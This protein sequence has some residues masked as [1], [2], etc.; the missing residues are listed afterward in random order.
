MHRP[1]ALAARR[2]ETRIDLAELQGQSFMEVRTPEEMNRIVM[3]ANQL[4]WK[5]PD[6][7]LL[8]EHPKNEYP[9]VAQ[10]L[11]TQLKKS[12]ARGR[13]LLPDLR[14]YDNPSVGVFSD[15]GGESTGNYHVYSAL[16]CG[17]GIT[18]VF[19]TKMRDVRA[20]HGLGEKEIEFKDFGMG[21]LLRALPDYL[22]ALD[23]LVPG[24]LCTLVVDKSLATL[25][26]SPEG[27]SLSQMPHS[28]GL[29]EWKPQVAEKLLRVVHLTAFLAA[30]LTHEGQKIF[31]M[32]DHDAICP[33]DKRHF[34]LLSVFERVLRV[35]TRP[36]CAFPI[37][38][39]AMPFAERSVEMMDLL[40]T[41]DIVAGSLADYFTKRD[42][43]PLE[44]IRVKQGTREVLKLQC[45]RWIAAGMAEHPS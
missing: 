41:A 17:Y 32:S 40:S 44:S 45:S 38:G 30:L 23:G 18:G 14:V 8:H 39:G 35:Y 37:V 25:F 9:L 24:F 12:H 4:V 19:N 34:D 36:G 21:Q 20:T 43:T 7:D 10:V 28:E 3:L 29:G 42:L 33:N 11:E 2:C 5:N 26:G 1:S 31:W 22:A 6:L 27:S 13:L 16:V 15:Y